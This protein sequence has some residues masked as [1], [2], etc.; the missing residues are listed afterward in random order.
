MICNKCN[1][2]VDKIYNI[3]IDPHGVWCDVD[4]HGEII[5]FVMSH[6]DYGKLDFEK[7]SSEN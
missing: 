5:K 1:K 3:V 6:F 4:C 2:K 7:I